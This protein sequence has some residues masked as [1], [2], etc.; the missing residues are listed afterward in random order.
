VS[1]AAPTAPNITRS[2]RHWKSRPA[3]ASFTEFGGIRS[4]NRRG[5]KGRAGFISS[6]SIEKHAGKIS[7]PINRTSVPIQ[8]DRIMM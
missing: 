2:P 1:C 8:S 3:P 6:G 4:F 5:S 7:R